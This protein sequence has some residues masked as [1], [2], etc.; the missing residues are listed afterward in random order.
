MGEERYLSILVND[1]MRVVGFEE[2]GDP[3]CM[4]GAGCMFISLAY[5]R[6]K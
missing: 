1:Y 2:V 6:A 3:C 4:Q 5:T